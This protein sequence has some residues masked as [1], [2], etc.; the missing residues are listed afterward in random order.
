MKMLNK[1]TKLLNPLNIYRNLR[2]NR[3]LINQMVVR[4]FGQRYR[5]SYLGVLWSVINP[6]LLLLIY[7]FVF[8]VVFKARWQPDQ[9]D[10]PLGQFAIV[11][12]S[13]L[14][15]YYFFSE[16]L[17]RAPGLVIGNPNYVKKVVFPLE[18]LVVVVGGTALFTSLI[19]LG[20]LLSA[21]LVFLHTLQPTVLLLPLVYLPLILLSVGLAWLLASLGVFIR[22][23]N[24]VI[25]LVLQVL[26]FVSPI[27]YPVSAVPAKFQFIMKLNPLTMIVT[28]FRDLIVYGKLFSVPEWGIWTVIGIFTA[29]FGY[30]WFM[31]TKKG[32]ADVL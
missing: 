24:L 6:L 21:M 23:I 31:W 13:G 9:E 11:L 22:D 18:V 7:T 3:Y 1:A 19:N 29:L 2:Q 28:A 32:F 15:P 27:F 16:V 8:S 17:S 25:A 30:T 26:L 12:F 5:G 4:D 14:I 10:V 20:I